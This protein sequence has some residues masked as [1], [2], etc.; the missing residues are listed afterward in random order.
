MHDADTR[1]QVA[2][3]HGQGRSMRSIAREVGVGLGTVSRWL[4]E[5]A[6]VH[7]GRLAGPTVA[8]LGNHYAE[9]LL[10]RS[11]IVAAEGLVYLRRVIA[12][13]EDADVRARVSASLGVLNSTA[14]LQAAAG[15]TPDVQAQIVIVQNTVPT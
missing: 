13:L 4:R 8:E 2:R 7:P 5:D 15:R 9:Q 3:L 12:G 10:A 14:R 1:T 6:P 11:E